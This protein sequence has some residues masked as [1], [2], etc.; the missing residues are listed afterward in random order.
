MKK[1]TFAIALLV[2]AL[3]AIGCVKSVTNNQQQVSPP[4]LAELEEK[5]KRHQLTFKEH[6][7]LAKARGKQKVLLPGYAV[8][9]P[10]AQTP[11][12]LNQYLLEYTIVIA[13]LIEVKG[14]IHADK[15][16]GSIY[17]WCK[18]KIIGMLSQAPP[19]PSYVSRQVP[20]ELLPVNDDE[21]VMIRSGG[22]V[23]VD[24]VEITINDQDVP[25]FRKSQRYLLLLSLDPS[26]KIAELAL[27]PQSMLP[28]NS[29]N[30]LDVKRD[31]H[32]LQ[33]VLRAYYGNSIEQL[34]R[35]LER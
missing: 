18:L 9:Y 31:G 11:N 5:E 13:E 29:D 34:K 26:T 16:G 32:I 8:L 19:R 33:R 3:T 7:Q 1:Q 12:E 30:T 21:F 27:G 22:T 25:A 6:A 14:Y 4:N 35:K 2:L 28:I 17:S 15:Y 23:T 24:G 10:V 20:D